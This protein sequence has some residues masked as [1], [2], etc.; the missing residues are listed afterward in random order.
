[1]LGP[2]GTFANPI[3]FVV[4]VAFIFV[5]YAYHLKAKERKKEIEKLKQKNL[6][7]EE[8]LEYV[9]KKRDIPS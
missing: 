5:L 7:L 6:K 9:R 4:M 2:W 1:M 8:A 3:T